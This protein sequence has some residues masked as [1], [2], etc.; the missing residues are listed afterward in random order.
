MVNQ[1]CEDHKI[2]ETLKIPE[3]NSRTLVRRALAV[4]VQT[5]FCNNLTEEILIKLKKRIAFL[6]ND[7]LVEDDDDSKKKK[8]ASVQQIYDKVV[9]FDYTKIGG[10][11]DLDLAEE[12]VKE[13]RSVLGLPSLENFQALDEKEKFKFVFTEKWIGVNHRPAVTFLQYLLQWAI[14]EQK[15]DE[16]L[17]FQSRRSIRR[18]IIFP[19]FRVNPHFTFL[20]LE[21]WFSIAKHFGYKFLPDDGGYWNEKRFNKAIARSLPW[22]K[23]DEQQYKYAQHDF[24]IAYGVLS[25]FMD[26]EFVKKVFVNKSGFRG[27]Q[28]DYKVTTDGES[29][30]LVFYKKIADIDNT[31]AKLV[32]KTFDDGIASAA[33]S[34]HL[35]RRSPKLPI[36]LI[37]KIEMKDPSAKIDFE[38]SQELI[39]GLLRSG[40]ARIFGDD[41]GQ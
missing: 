16:S 34:I 26:L 12:F 1:A 9:G 15:S 19:Q 29:C 6:I 11:T 28:F 21:V 3:I 25:N 5:A 31:A 4:Q 8:Y 27:M 32:K 2:L 7:I 38:G 33:R 23:K 41:P 20:N 18:P 13:C 14:N 24:D 22:N 10:V 40:Q 37:R 36:S 30:H 35:R 39:E 17:S